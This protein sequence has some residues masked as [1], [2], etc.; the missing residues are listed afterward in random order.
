MLEHKRYITQ[1]SKDDMKAIA[2]AANMHAGVGLEINND[3]NG[4]EISIDKQT[5][6]MFV[7]AI[8]AGKEI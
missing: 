2:A 8:I 1:L 6:R 7:R 4:L 3:G 5:L